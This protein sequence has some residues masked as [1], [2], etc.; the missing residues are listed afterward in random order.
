MNYYYVT[1]DDTLFSIADRYQVTVNE[2]KEANGLTSDKL[3]IGQR[4]LI[5]IKESIYDRYTVKAGDNIYKI[6]NI[7]KI[8]PDLLLQINGMEKGET[9][10]IGQ[11]LLVPRKGFSFVITK[12][13]DTIR[14]IANKLN[15]TVE[16]LL[17]SNLAIYLLPDQLIVYQ[18]LQKK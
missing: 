5:P 11:I 16:Q 6:A 15:T 14:G 12:E 9:L 13:G 17:Y 1:K 4:L 18:N 8:T 7:Y 10:R 3:L 2:L